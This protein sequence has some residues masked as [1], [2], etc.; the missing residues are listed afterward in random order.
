MCEGSGR[1]VLELR[2]SRQGQGEGMALP[3]ERCW[4]SRYDVTRG[5]GVRRTRN[6]VLDIPLMA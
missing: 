1:K 5:V 4:T 3:A 6:H 2:A